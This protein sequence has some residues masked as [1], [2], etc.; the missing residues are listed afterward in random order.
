MLQ[1]GCPESG[2]EEAVARLVTAGYKVVF[3]LEI[4]C[5]HGRNMQT[6]YE[7]NY[8]EQVARMEQMETA[9]EAKA[10]RGPKAT[11]RRQLTR[12]HTPAT[13]TGQQ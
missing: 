3:A 13:A 5:T 6:L 12:V 7:R 11:I 10:A 9:Q 2:V 8:V 1:V 4:F